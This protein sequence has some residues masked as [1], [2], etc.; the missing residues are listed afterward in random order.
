[1]NC[2]VD[3][4]RSLPQVSSKLNIIMNNKIILIYIISLTCIL[5]IDIDST[6][7]QTDTKSVKIEYKG[8]EGPG[9]NKHIVLISGDEEYRSEEMLPQLAKVL[10][11]RHGFKTTVLF[12]VNPETGYIDPNYQQNIPGLEVLE[13]ADLMILFIRFRSLP[14]RQIKHIIQY[15]NDGKPIIGIRPAIAAF[16]YKDENSPYAKYNFNSN[17]P[18]WE[19]GFSRYFFGE[20][21]R[22]HHGEHLKEGTKAIVNGPLHEH[23]ILKGVEDVWCPTDVYGIVGLKNVEDILLYGVSLTGMNSDSAPNLK[24]SVMPVAWTKNYKAESGNVGRSFFTT[25]GTSVTLENEGFR[26]LL[27]N[28]SYWGLEMEELIEEKFDVRL[29]GNYD[30]TFF[31]FDKFRK[32]LTPDS[33]KLD[34]K[35]LK[36]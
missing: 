27:V 29:A 11:Y 18:G 14:P 33:F 3:A 30:P 9:A 36:H 5:V 1:L 32:N 4:L 2:K 13:D 26:R 34:K 31:G 23:P 28:A 24:K 35:T 12:P 19:G 20:T 16:W 6:S 7:A 17:I 15:L 22:Y 10:A 8:T 25:M 21:W